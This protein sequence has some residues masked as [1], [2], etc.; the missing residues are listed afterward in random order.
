MYAAESFLS[1]KFNAFDYYRKWEFLFLDSLAV[2]KRFRGRGI[3]AQF[4]DARLLS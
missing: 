2:D 4:F 3:G 1:K